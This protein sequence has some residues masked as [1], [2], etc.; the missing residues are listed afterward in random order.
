MSKILLKKVS[1]NL[2]AISI[3]FLID[4]L[5]KLYI[6]KISR[7]RKF[8]RYIFDIL[9]KFIFNLEQGDSIWFIVYE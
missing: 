4:R 9:S 6:L 3:I 5:T 8:G 2:T 7:N 1:L